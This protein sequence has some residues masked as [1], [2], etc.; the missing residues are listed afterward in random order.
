[1]DCSS[2]YTATLGKLPTVALDWLPAKPALRPRMK[3]LPCPGP[4]LANVMFGVS[5]M[6]SSK[7]VIARDASPAPENAWIVMG[8]SCRD[9]SRRW[10]VTTSSSSWAPEPAPA[11]AASA[12]AAWA[13]PPLPLRI[14]ATAQ[15]TMYLVFA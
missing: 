3:M 8:T 2:R 14:A 10:A 12:A 1:M 6:R 4:F 15:E 7:V 9:C 11:A 13:T 5:L